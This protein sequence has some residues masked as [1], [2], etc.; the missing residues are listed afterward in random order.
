ME[1]AY[2]Y[3]LFVIL[4]LTGFCFFLYSKFTSENDLSDYACNDPIFVFIEL[5]QIPN[6]KYGLAVILFILYMCYINNRGKF[7]I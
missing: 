6:V 4:M 5:K 2:L 1:S 7:F 3:D